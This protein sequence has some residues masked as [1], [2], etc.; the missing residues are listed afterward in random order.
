MIGPNPR[1]RRK[2]K[3]THPWKKGQETGRIRKEEREKSKQAKPI[4]NMTSSPWMEDEG[5]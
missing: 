2:V 5:E 3:R 4:I 1:M